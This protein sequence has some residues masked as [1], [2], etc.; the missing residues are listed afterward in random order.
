MFHKAKSQCFYTDLCTQSKCPLLRARWE[1]SL[2]LQGFHG[3]HLIKSQNP[4]SWLSCPT[5]YIIVILLNPKSLGCLLPLTSIILLL[6]SLL[7]PPA[8]T[9]C[10][11]CP[12]QSQIS[13]FLYILQWTT[14]MT[15][16]D[17][18][19]C[20]ISLLKQDDS[21]SQEKKSNSEKQKSTSQE[22]KSN[23]SVWKIPSAFVL[24]LVEIFPSSQETTPLQ[25]ICLGW[26][27]DVLCH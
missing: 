14:L 26:W 1:H 16:V 4:V 18:S 7:L 11:V 27:Q 15:L 24:G 2:I 8:W 3:H 13:Q 12:I 20:Q 6:G 21:K 19:L 9:G 5:Y 10:N 23:G 22:S 17:L 25:R